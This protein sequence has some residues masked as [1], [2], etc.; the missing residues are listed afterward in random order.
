M[1]QKKVCMLGAVAVGKTSLVQRFVH[2][3]FSEKYLA[4]LGVKIDKKSIRIGQQD[5]NLV[6][7]DLQAEDDFQMVQTSYLRGASGCL[8]VVDG[9]R[10]ETL[11]KAF[12]LKERTEQVVRGVPF[13][14]L[15]NKRDLL[16]EW[17]LGDSV[18]AD[19]TGKGW[20]TIETSAKTGDRVE[21]GFLTLGRRMLAE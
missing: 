19:C 16:D 2:S 20:V 11:D 12:E 17:E 14:I 4:T 13:V 15:L 10:R 8:L 18:V 9:T 21:E 7:W 3:M 1:I 5:V 6:L